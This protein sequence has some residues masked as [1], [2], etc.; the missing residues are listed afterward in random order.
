EDHDLPRLHRRARTFVIR[1]AFEFV[2]ER[3]EGA[4]HVIRHDQRLT[5]RLDVG[6][7][8]RSGRKEI[9]GRRAGGVALRA[10]I[11]AALARAWSGRN[12]T[13]TVLGDIS[14]SAPRSGR[15][16]V[17]HAAYFGSAGRVGHHVI[18]VVT[19]AFAAVAIRVAPGGLDDRRRA[20]LGGFG[21]R[22]VVT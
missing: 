4:E 22:V 11:T 6:L 5:D 20:G 14:A 21:D 1:R 3:G 19:H 13:G 15:V 2:N 17:E 7:G 12:L 8:E 18:H 16:L 9:G 10:P